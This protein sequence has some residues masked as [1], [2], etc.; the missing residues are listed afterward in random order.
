MNS[1]G[2]DKAIYFVDRIKDKN[3][4]Y[5]SGRAIYKKGGKISL[6]GL[7]AKNGTMVLKYVK[8]AGKQLVFKGNSDL[9]SKQYNIAPKSCYQKPDATNQ[10]ELL[11]LLVK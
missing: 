5:T 9:F 11:S 6:N 2:S 8:D 4:N 7:T 1:D 3:G 10:G